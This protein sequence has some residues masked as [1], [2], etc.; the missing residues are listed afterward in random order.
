LASVTRSVLSEL[1]PLLEVQHG[2]FYLAQ[3]DGGKSYL[4]FLSGYA[5]T[6]PAPEAREWEL[7]QGL[8]GQCA[9]EKKRILLSALPADYI[10]IASGTGQAAAATLLLLPVLGEGKLLGV[11]ELASLQPLT[12]QHLKFVEQ[13]LVDLGLVLNSIIAY[14]RTE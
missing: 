4:R 10:R 6:A 3:T 8:V 12:A 5:V 2:A 9:A 7:G 1:A 11:L 13:F 14:R